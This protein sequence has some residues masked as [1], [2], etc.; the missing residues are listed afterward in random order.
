MKTTQDLMLFSR[1]MVEEFF[2]NN[3]SDAYNIIKQTYLDFSKGASKNPPSS[4]L[5]YD[6]DTNSRI[7]GLAAYLGDKK[8]YPG[9]KWIASCPHNIEH[10]LPRASAVIILN[11]FTTGFPVAVIEGA[12][13]SALRTAL[14]AIL[15]LEYLHPE[16]TIPN[17]GIVGGGN[18]ATVFL[19]CLNLLGW[20]FD[21]CQI[22]DKQNT[23][24]MHKEKRLVGISNINYSVDCNKM[25]KNSD[26]VLFATTAVTPYIN[27]QNLFKLNAVIL[28]LSL[29]DI[30]P[31][32]ILSAYNIV[33]D[34]E[35]ILAANTSPH[36]A[37]LLSGNK[38]FIAG[39][40]MQLVSGQI[41]V[42]EHKLKIFSPMGMGILDIAMA[43]L[44]LANNLNM[45]QH[46]VKDF[47]K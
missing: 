37:Y 45:N 13:I 18:L 15:A 44:L 31:E 33:D 19:Q 12:T 39:N 24:I 46:I 1:V 4:F 6:N 11:D 16:K 14:S 2:N 40:I 26:V 17:L 29:R 20:K 36:L 9:I 5:W 7:I 38:D 22:Y 21:S 42:A 47:F 10:G 23:Q 27:D 8:S 34:V 35:H 3:I 41:K 28:N 30:S 43:N 32:I 25:L